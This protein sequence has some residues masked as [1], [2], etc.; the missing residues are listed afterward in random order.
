MP[1]VVRA[2][3]RGRL[4][5]VLAVIATL[6]ARPGLAQV[7]DT[8]DPS[9]LEWVPW[10]PVL[11][12]PSLESRWTWTDNL[13][14]VP[15]EGSVSN[16][17]RP[18]SSGLYELAP[19]VRFALPYSNSN[20]EL[21]Y[22]PLY[23]DYTATDL[24]QHYAHDIVGRNQ[25]VLSNGMSIDA[26]FTRSR[27]TYELNQFDRA[28]QVNFATTPFRSTD[29]E[30]SWEWTHPSRWG[31]V[32]TVEGLW[33]SFD[34]EK[35]PQP[36]DDEVELLYDNESRSATLDVNW[37]LA[38]GL[39]VFGGVAVTRSKVDAIGE[40]LDGNGRLDDVEE[41]FTTG[42]PLVSETQ[43]FDQAD[44]RIGLAGPLGPRLELRGALA[45]TRLRDLTE[46]GDAF[47]GFTT[48]FESHL[49]LTRISQ[50]DVTFERQP[51]QTL[52]SRSDTFVYRAERVGWTLTGQRHSFT[53]GV[54]SITSRLPDRRENY[55][56]IE[57][58][59]GVK[60]RRWLG[61][62]AGVSR[63]VK[64]SSSDIFDYDES[65]AD[66]GVLIGWI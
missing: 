23:R 16:G 59:W 38:P 64:D 29:A 41:G 8:P 44:L 24:P 57:G 28:G 9:S 20:F 18:Q 3:P 32:L 10:G 36:P 45:R 60:I 33:V 63:A 1:A 49:R 47:R 30:V 5:R 4:P 34:N 48:R 13:F 14:R 66:L 7:P 6:I 26:N 51:Q 37:F 58:G 31:T 53:A 21:D 25:I 39:A 54:N 43:R 22:K 15:D 55:L 40:D 61:V 27:G 42:G 19:V 46:E 56:I 62:R 35:A 17:A 65:R 50:L 52:T 11:V 2:A 12:A